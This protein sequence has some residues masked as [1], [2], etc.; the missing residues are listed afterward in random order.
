MIDHILNAA[1]CALDEL[2][3]TEQPEIYYQMEV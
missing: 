1:T 3:K 2:I